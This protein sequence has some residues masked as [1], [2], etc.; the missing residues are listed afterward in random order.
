MKDTK[1]L[2][3]FLVTSR[4]IA[5]IT[6][7]NPD[8]DA[9]GSALGLFHFLKEAGHE[10]YP[11][12]PN[13]YPKFLDW[14]PGNQEVI[15]FEDETAYASNLLANSDLLF[16]LDFSGF[17]RVKEMSD[18]AAG[19]PAKI[20]LVDHHLNP[21]IK[22]DFNFWNDKATATAELVFDLILELSGRGAVSK[23]I[24]E[25][26]Y[27]G[28]MTDTGSF[29]HP[30]TSSKVHR[31]VADL[32]DLGANV[33]KVS[34]LIYD[35]NSLNKLKFLGYS[36]AEKLQVCEKYQLAYFVITKRDFKKF[37]LEQGDTEGL[38][39]Y[40]LSIKGI[41]IAAI[42]IERAGEIKLSFRSVGDYA[43]NTFAEKYFQ[44]GGHKNA[45]GGNSGQSLKETEK[46][47]IELIKQNILKTK[48]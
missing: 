14:M 38:V 34:R 43:V 15:A 2:K 27:A 25:C 46:V 41:V 26:L 28:I 29:K 30:N 36:L 44:G 7:A 10:V 8:A 4:K 23:E 17:N 48:I 6:H 32:I 20:A 33:N 39:N 45:A 47:F 24:A 40:A 9:L 42:I 18:A 19:A 21:E 12:V 3:D 11:I 5:I 37:D 16:C 35:T 31:I 1:A 22:P 13:S